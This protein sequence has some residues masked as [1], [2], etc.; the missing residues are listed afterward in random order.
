MSKLVVKNGAKVT[1]NL[2]SNV[3]GDSNIETNFPLKLLLTDRQ[4]SRLCKACANNLS[5]NIKLSKAQLSK[6]V[7]SGGFLGRLCG[8]LLEPG[9]SLIKK[10][11]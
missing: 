1:L 3:I 4:F 6:I 8:Q 2:S 9:L 7:Q 5:A 10:C 11:T